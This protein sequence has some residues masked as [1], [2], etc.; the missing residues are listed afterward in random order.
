MGKKLKAIQNQVDAAAQVLKADAPKPS[1]QDVVKER[2][3]NLAISFVN[4]MKHARGPRPPT[5]E[6]LLSDMQWLINRVAAIQV[7]IEMMLNN[8]PKSEG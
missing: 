2:V 7:T 8:K 6:E 3:K 4:E 5:H 1:E